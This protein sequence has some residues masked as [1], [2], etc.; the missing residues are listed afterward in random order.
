MLFPSQDRSAAVDESAPPASEASREITALLREMREG[1]EGEGRLIDAVYGDLKAIARGR[2]LHERTGHTLATTDLVHE[3]YLRL[4]D[5]KQTDWRDRAHFFS[6]AAMTM[7]RVLVDHARRH[8]A[9]KRGGNRR[10]VSLDA[11]DLTVDEQAVLIVEVN[12]ALEKLGAVSERLARVVEC[13]WFAALTDAETA[14]ALGMSERTVRRE[15]TKARAML[16][17]ALAG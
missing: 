7:R 17:H 4:V 12:D 8:L 16:R 6:V 1:R 5:Q 9:E 3:S 14:D 2:L 11:V 15:W 13:R 10:A